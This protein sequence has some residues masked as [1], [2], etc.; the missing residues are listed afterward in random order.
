MDTEYSTKAETKIKELSLEAAKADRRK[1]ADLFI[2][3]TKTTDPESKK[4]LLVESRS[5]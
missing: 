5:S 1:A 4:K 2:R 3:F